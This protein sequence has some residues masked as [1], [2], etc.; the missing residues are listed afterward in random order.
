MKKNEA[1][2]RIAGRFLTA[3]STEARRIVEDEL[4]LKVYAIMREFV[5]FFILVIALY[6]CSVITGK[7]ASTLSPSW[8]ERKQQILDWARSEK[9]K[10]DSGSLKNSEYWRQ[11]YQK[12]IELRPDLD[13]FLCY[14]NEM[15][16]ISKIFEEGKITKQ[17]FEDKQRQ[18]SDLLAQE[19][20]R[21]AEI[22]SG[23]RIHEDNEAALFFFYS[24][25]L[26][27]GYI[28]D[29]RSQLSKTGLQLSTRNCA[30][31]GDS[32]HCSD[33]NPFF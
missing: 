27:T 10:V 2:G 13:D 23:T 7:K 30:F 9:T 20:K 5:F 24:K 17:Q 29:L 22:L 28:E 18:L 21:R 32:V 4:K 3:G 12:S 31:F 8:E 11:F 16:K 1:K 25:S 15:I 6:G 14:A 19:E 33:Q 26:F